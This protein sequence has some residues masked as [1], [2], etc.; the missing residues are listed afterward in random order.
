MAERIKNAKQVA[1][2]CIILYAIVAAGYDHDRNKIVEWLKSERLWQFTSPREQA[3]LT[4]KRPSK[5]QV[6]D[7]TWRVEALASLSWAIN[8]T[9]K[10]DLG[11]EVELSNIVGKLPRLFTD[12]QAF[13]SNASILSN[14]ELNREHDAVDHAHWRIRDARRNKKPEPSDLA[15]EAIP[16]RHKALNWLL[17]WGGRAWDNITTD[18]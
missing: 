14:E 16:E 13:I 10:P 5:Q 12:T 15:C 6:I 3:F 8:A 4:S 17:G 7:A 18:T 1:R 2:R 11:K 9:I